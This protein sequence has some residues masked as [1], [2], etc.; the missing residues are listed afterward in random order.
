LDESLEFARAR[1]DQARI[2]RRTRDIGTSAIAEG[3]FGRARRALEESA[4]LSRRLG[5][6]D[7]ASALER[8]AML[9]RLEGDHAG[10]RAR[11][12]ELRP[13]AVSERGHH[14]LEYLLGTLA[15]AEGRY[16]E[17]RHSLAAIVQRGGEAGWGLE[18]AEPL[19][20][21]GVLEIARGALARGVC[22][23]AA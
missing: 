19:C 2:I 12:D 13:M 18:L 21:L 4:T 23:I 14:S 5:A 11:V 1:S 10:A 8:L 20:M 3:D 17:A 16:A 6:L 15:R 22:I 9:D 7:L